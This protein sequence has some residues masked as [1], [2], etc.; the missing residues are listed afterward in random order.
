MPTAVSVRYSWTFPGGAPG[1]SSVATPGNVSYSTP[2]TYVASLTVTDNQGLA[3]QPV[4]RTVTVS[5]FTVSATPASQTVVAGQGTTYTATVTP[6]SGFT[7][8]VDFSVTGLPS[9]ATA[10]FT[11]PSVAGSG[12]TSMSISTTAATASGSY[13]LVISGTSG[14]ITRTANVTLVVKDRPGAP[15]PTITSTWRTFLGSPTT[16]IHS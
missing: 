10:T 12:S 7:G 6:A 8:T 1:S 9:G 13:P 14:P 11:P 15:P 16:I 3:S 4:T 5:N 2:G